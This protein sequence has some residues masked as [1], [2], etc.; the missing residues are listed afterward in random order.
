MPSDLMMSLYPIKA[1]YPKGS[2]TS[3]SATLGINTLT[4]GPLGHTEKLK[5]LMKQYNLFT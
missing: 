4:H 5:Q 2:T 1:L 3:N